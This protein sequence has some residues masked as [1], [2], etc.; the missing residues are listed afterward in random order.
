VR[1]CLDLSSP[2]GGRVWRQT[3]GWTGATPPAVPFGPVCPD[4]GAGSSGIVASHVVNGESTPLFRFNPPLPDV[5]TGADYA[6]ITHVTVDLLVNS[7]PA[8]QRK[9]SRLTSGVYLRNQADPPTARFDALASADG[10][11]YLNASPSTDPRGVAL[12]YR[13]CDT[14]AGDCS[15]ATTIGQGLTL[16]YAAP[17]GTREITL[18][19]TNAAG[20][21]ASATRLVDVP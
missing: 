10:T 20:I 13:W 15:E 19:V 6:R 16:R 14:T 3:F 18:V 7:D 21:S 11:V 2:A 1:Y 5:P 12:T 8:R 9:P 4:T 17:S